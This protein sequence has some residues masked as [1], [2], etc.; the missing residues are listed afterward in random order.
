M[1]NKGAQKAEYGSFFSDLTRTIWSVNVWYGQRQ[2]MSRA[3]A[4]DTK[5]KYHK[6][7]SITTKIIAT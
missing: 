3:V 2:I 1:S 7:Y 6:V 5:A 4:R